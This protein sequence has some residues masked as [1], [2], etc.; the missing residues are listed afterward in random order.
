MSELLS[1]ARSTVSQYLS[2]TTDER[3]LPD[4]AAIGASVAL[5]SSLMA[6]S[7]IS[8][9][10]TPKIIVVGTQSSGK[11]SLLNALMNIEL[12]PVGDTMTTRA[13]IHVQLINSKN[14]FRV[15]FGDYNNGQ[16]CLIKT[17]EINS[18][19]TSEQQE[20]IKKEINSQTFQKTL[21]NKSISVENAICLRLYSSSVPNICFVDLPGLTMT[22]LTSEGQPANLCEQ[23]RELV[24]TYT[25]ERTIIL[26]VCAARPDLEADAAM[27]LC[28]KL[29]GGSR[30]IGCLTK[31]DLCDSDVTSYIEGTQ[32][33]DLS[34]E[35]GYFAVK[36][37]GK[38]NEIVSTLSTAEKTFFTSH[39]HFKHIKQQ[40]HI[41][42]DNLAVYIHRLYIHEIRSCLPQLRKEL[43]ILYDD[44]RK[45]YTMKIG[46]TIPTGSSERLVFAS[47]LVSN[48]ANSLKTSFTSRQPD[49]S[50]GRLVRQT[51]NNLATNTRSISPF[52]SDNFSDQE[53]MKAVQNCEGW[54]MVSPI[55]PIGIV[56]FFLQHNTKRPILQLQEPC[57]SALQS[58]L[59]QLQESSDEL[60]QKVHRFSNM[61]SWLQNELSII[62]ENIRS[63]TEKEINT[64]IFVEESYIFTDDSLFIKEWSAASHKASTTHQSY[65][66]TL[67]QILSAYYRVVAESVISY[68]PKLIVYALT[69]AL[70]NLQAHLTSQLHG[71]DI[72]HLL[73]E[74]EET[75]SLRVKLTQMIN[76]AETSIKTIDQVFEM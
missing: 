67:R 28:K 51:F 27:E 34:L 32:S 66:N 26:M 11:S 69:N 30:T 42:I 48:F 57:S 33:A 23:I 40:D 63:N 41:G 7:N 65:P 9:F 15:E 3:I 72:T 61:R 1:Y 22:A 45:E 31:I 17:L 16:W 2:T 73:L 19:P 8:E 50:A 70:N 39:P 47:E 37:R 76:T 59:T 5:Q 12:L 10:K 29:T 25:D 62:I 53:I 46:S 68:V 71:S 75:E 20:L 13:A 24:S 74:D 14:K 18:N 52:N 36:C 54:S 35:H 49:A 38:P 56:E 6:L 21:N 4:P 55:P 44:A 43:Q 58:I 64:A 60:T